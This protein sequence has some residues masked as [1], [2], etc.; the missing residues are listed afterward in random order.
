MKVHDAG[1]EI[2]PALTFGWQLPAH[3]ALE[4]L[5]VFGSEAPQRKAAE[6]AYLAP[7]RWG[8]SGEGDHESDEEIAFDAALYN[9]LVA[10]CQDFGIEKQLS[11]SG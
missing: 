7:W 3:D 2:G 11:L 4:R 1:Y 9:Y 6:D 10:V 5:R 8:D